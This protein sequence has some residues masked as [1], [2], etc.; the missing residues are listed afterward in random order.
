MNNS[1][2]KAFDHYHL[3]EHLFHTTFPMAKDP[4]LFVGMVKSISNCLEEIL[5]LILIQ[6][7]TQSKGNLQGDINVVRPFAEKY[8]LSPADFTFM[9]RI[10]ELLAKQKQSPIEFKRGNLQVIC[11]EDYELEAL[12]AKEVDSFL[13]H[14]RKLLEKVEKN[15]KT[16]K[17]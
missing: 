10:Q 2:N 15:L 9:L 12:S 16:Q 11:S 8:N 13:L 5:F 1:L 3:A 7:K 4:K 17:L 6:E 14:S